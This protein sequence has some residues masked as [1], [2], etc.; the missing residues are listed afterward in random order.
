[1]RYNA[2][3]VGNLFPTFQDHAMVQSLRV[4]MSRQKDILT[5][6]DDITIV[7]VIVIYF[8]FEQIQVQVIKIKFHKPLDME[9]VTNA[10]PSIA[11]SQK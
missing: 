2:V 9:C 7:I 8:K 4:E 1:V 10:Q 3:A 5:F 11:T 6:E